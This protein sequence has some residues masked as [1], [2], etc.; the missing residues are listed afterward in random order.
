[1]TRPVRP[2]ALVRLSFVI[3]FVAGQD[4][5]RPILAQLGWFVAESDAERDDPR[6][7]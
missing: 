1:M 4:G 6:A 5:L 3:E 2:V 7:S